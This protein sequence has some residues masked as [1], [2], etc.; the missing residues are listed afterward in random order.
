MLRFLRERGNTWVLKGFLGVVALTFVSWGGY[1]SMTSGN[2]V[3]G[4]R[5]AAWVNE[6]PISVREFESRYY[7]QAES[8]RQRLGAA[9][10]PELERQLNL[11]RATF[12][13]IVSEM[14]QLTE[15]ARLGIEVSDAE[16]ALSIQE[17]SAFQI[18][19]R[20]DSVR[21][22]Q[23]LR[24]NRLNAR[25]YEKSQRRAIATSRLRRYLGLG[26]TIVESEVRDAYR[27]RNE[28]IRLDIIRIMPEMFS[29]EVSVKDE[30][31]KAYFAK[32]KATFRTGP[33]R[34]AKWWFLPYAAVSARM[35]F[36]E[37]DLISHYQDT[38]SRYKVKES[39]TVHQILRKVLPDAKKEKF[40]KAKSLLARIRKQIAAGKSFAELAKAN[41]EGPAASKGGK[42]GVFERGQMLPVLEKIVFALKA[43]K[44]SQ[45]IQ[46]SFGVHLILVSKHTR[47]GV[48]PFSE[49]RSKV[50]ASL[51]DQKARVAAKKMLRLVRYDVEDKKPVPK[52]AG[53][54]SGGTGFFER[55][56]PPVLAPER[57]I[58][59][60]LV[61]ELKKK[62]D[63][64][65]E[66]TGEKGTIFVRLVDMKP[67][68]VPPLKSVES[69]VRAQYILK[70]AG[71]IADRKS[72]TWLAQLQKGEKK[73]D[74]LA[75]DLKVKISQP[76]PFSR[77]VAPAE[78]REEAGTIG[79]IFQLK[80]GKFDRIRNRGYFLMLRGGAPPSVDMSKYREQKKKLSEGL[81]AA[82][83]RN[84]FTRRMGDIQ[85][86]A[87]IRFEGGFSL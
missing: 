5:V 54:Q 3:S 14:L 6:N 1:S 33:K 56:R 72:E 43:G 58:I 17:D 55:G 26:A 66:R 22:K 70:K 38:R 57:K 46:T 7:R 44:V 75:A 60:R 20:F 62:G 42:L 76:E 15:A 81:L 87:K 13:Q 32:D 71:E 52:T 35:T 23:V 11:R 25:Q 16:V 74:A 59:S 64:S 48:L 45:P 8:M 69:R 68:E 79:K 18:A 40:E 19:G 28:K 84:I 85:K 30:D 49:V 78:F 61:F 63:L 31:L 21:Y 37:H 10:T 2:A 27:W 80:K 9:F 82:K 36:K 39:V 4:G 67:S 83:S 73:F 65:T 34:K 51:R 77:L 53:L 86:A 50:E 12:Q 47:G 24:E 41:S 29:K